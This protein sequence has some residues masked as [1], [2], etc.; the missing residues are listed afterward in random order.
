VIDDAGPEC[1]LHFDAR[2]GVFVHVATYGFGA[3]TIGVRTAPSLTG[4]WSAP[5]TVFRPVESD[6]PRPFVYAG[7]AHPELTGP[8]PGDLVVTYATNSF[9]FGDLFGP[10]GAALYWPRFVAVRIP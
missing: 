4:P 1:S 9:E 6:G 7:K 8:E 2:T 3:T 10:A 5:Q